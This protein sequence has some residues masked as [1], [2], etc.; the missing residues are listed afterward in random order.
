MHKVFDIEHYWCP[1]CQATLRCGADGV[2]KHKEVY[3]DPDFKY[4]TSPGTYHE[5]PINQHN[6]N[7]RH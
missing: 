1:F 6:L 5:V 7:R 4:K 3:H 2:F